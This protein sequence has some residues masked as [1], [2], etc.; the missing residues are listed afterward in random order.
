MC[1]KRIIYDI[2]TKFK[3]ENYMFLDTSQI[4]MLT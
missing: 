4:D 3:F 1:I 2:V